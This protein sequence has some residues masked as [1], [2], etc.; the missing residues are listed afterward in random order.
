MYIVALNLKQALFSFNL[1]LVTFNWTL[2]FYSTTETMNQSKSS[3]PKKLLHLL[4]IILIQIQKTTAVTKT[5]LIPQ[6][7]QNLFYS[8]SCSTLPLIITAPDKHGSLEE[9]L[10]IVWALSS[11]RS[12]TSWLWSCKKSI[13]KPDKKNTLLEEDLGRFTTRHHRREAPGN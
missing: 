7:L 4:L 3:T 10:L 11:L 8:I 5:K 13:F 12:Q 2:N 1:T 9:H 6:E